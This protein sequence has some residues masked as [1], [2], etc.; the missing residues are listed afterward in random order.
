MLGGGAAGVGHVDMRIGAVG[1]QRVGMF[2]HLGRDIGVQI[3]AD[4]QRQVVADHLAHA[5]QDF[6]FAVVEMFG[7]HGAVQVEIDGVERSRRLDAVDHHLDDALK[8]ILGHMRRG[9]GAA[10][11]RRHHL[12][13]LGFRR[14]DK[15]GQPD[16][17]VAHDL[18]HVG[19]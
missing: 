6:A 2:D 7:D 16:I 19:A 10:G 8:G 17:D 9:A 18:E 3:E 4:H 1:N 15:A 12:P 11:N 5:R 13:A 14:F